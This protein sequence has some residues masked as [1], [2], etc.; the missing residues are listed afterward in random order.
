ME[1]ILK[2]IGE[3]FRSLKLKG[4]G[5]QAH[6]VAQARGNKF[7]SEEG[8]VGITPDFKGEGESALEALVNLQKE[9]KLNQE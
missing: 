3:Q 7:V 5:T 4:K 6:W 1:N 8:R 2:E 9:T